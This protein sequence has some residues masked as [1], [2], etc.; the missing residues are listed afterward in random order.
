MT[1]CPDCGAETKPL[2]I[3]VYCT[4]DCDKKAL[5]EWHEI[6]K[7]IPMT[8]WEDDLGFVLDDEGDT[9]P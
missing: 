4:A 3:G 1:T 7:V 6:T 2:L 9:Q 5:R 8:T